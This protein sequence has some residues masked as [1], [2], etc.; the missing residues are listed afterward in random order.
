MT[1]DISEI[2]GKSHLYSIGLSSTPLCVCG[3][4]ETVK[5][6]LLDCKLYEQPRG[7]LFEKLEGLLEM[8]VSKYSKANLCDILEPKGCICWLKQINKLLISMLAHKTK[9]DWLKLPK[10]NTTISSNHHALVTTCNYSVTILCSWFFFSISCFTQHPSNHVV[11]CIR[12]LSSCPRPALSPKQA[13]QYQAH[14]YTSSP[15]L[16]HVHLYVLCSMCCIVWRVLSVYVCVVCSFLRVS[17]FS[18]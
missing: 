4:P 16:A 3:Q 18:A 14:N 2:I 8:R 17:F 13:F 15:R 7:Q 1:S 5:H 9:F 11:I 12:I 10:I 6:F